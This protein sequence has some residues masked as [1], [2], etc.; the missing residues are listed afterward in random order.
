MRCRWLMNSLNLSRK[1]RLLKLNS[2]LASSLETYNGAFQTALT[3]QLHKSDSQNAPWSAWLMCFTK[4]R[5]MKHKLF[6]LNGIYLMFI[7]FNGRFL[8]IDYT[9]HWQTYSSRISSNKSEWLSQMKIWQYMFFFFYLP[10]CSNDRLIITHC[11]FHSVV[12]IRR[13]DKRNSCSNCCGCFNFVK[14]SVLLTTAPNIW[15]QDH[16]VSTLAGALTF[17][18]SLRAKHTALTVCHVAHFVSLFIIYIIFLFFRD[19]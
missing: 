19:L 3:E 2:I 15:H 17:V 9:L 1:R 13:G 4:M 16:F 7:S 10:D 12:F 18:T 8:V 5:E 11:S 14:H 6:L